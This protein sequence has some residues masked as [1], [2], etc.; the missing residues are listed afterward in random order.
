MTM[1]AFIKPKE[2]VHQTELRLLSDGDDLGRL[3]LTVAFEDEG[4]AGVV[5]VVPGSLDEETPYMT[6]TGLGDG[7]PVLPG[8]G[9]VLRRHQPEVG[10]EG[11]WGSEAADIADFHQKGKSSEGLDASET[12]ES[13][14]CLS[15]AWECSIAL[16]FCVEGRLLRLEV[17]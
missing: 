12:A 6:V 17:L 16:E 13:F 7:T 2:L 14:D 5:T 4:S 11:A 1:F 9:G 8:A 10:H 3:P 15:V